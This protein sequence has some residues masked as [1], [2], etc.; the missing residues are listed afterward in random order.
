MRAILATAAVLALAAMAAGSA[1]VRMSETA[2]IDSSK[3]TLGDVAAIE[4]LNAAER[5][6]M[7]GV[8]VAYMAKSEEEKRVDGETVRAALSGAGVNVGEVNICGAAATKVSRT[9]ASAGTKLMSAV[10]R[11]LAAAAP[12]KHFAVTDVTFD[13]TPG[14]EF[15]PTV[16]AAHPQELSGRVR[17]DV[18]GAGDASTVVGHIYATLS[19]T[20]PVVVAK[21]RLFGGQVVAAEDLKTEYR[22]EAEAAGALGDAGE[23]AGKRLSATLEAG[24]PV[25]AAGLQSNDA[26]KRGD[27]VVIEYEK[28]ALAISIRA[29]ALENGSVGDVIRLKRPG[30]R[31]EHTARIVA[32]GRAVP[33]TGG[34][35]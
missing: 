24:R 17:L 21:R 20:T 22:S 2:T 19:K 8:V 7:A 34:E 27:T 4:T 29:A 26:V 35:K 5:S 9:A 30:E 32:P 11:Y 1:T 25:M 28:G 33:A 23:A 18:A 3:V 13:F 16:T 10:D 6:K 14:L 31:T 15:E 12:K